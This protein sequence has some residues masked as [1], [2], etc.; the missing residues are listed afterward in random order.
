[1]REPDGAFVLVVCAAGGVGFGAALVAAGLLW[2]LAVVALVAVSGV[3]ARRIALAVPASGGG[4]S[5]EIKARN[6]VMSPNNGQGRPSAQATADGRQ[7]GRL[8]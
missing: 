7:S 5:D 3:G 2:A 1:M 8:V 4:L 6:I